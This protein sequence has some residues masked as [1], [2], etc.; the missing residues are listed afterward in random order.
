MP[1][2]R[3]A[4]C[5]VLLFLLLLQLPM[6]ANAELTKEGQVQVLNR[7]N[8]VIEELEAADRANQPKPKPKPKKIDTSMAQSVLEHVRQVALKLARPMRV[9]I[10][11]R[12]T[13]SD[14]KHSF[15]D[16]I[17]MAH[18]RD[19][20][21]I[22]FTEHDRTAVRYGID[23]V[24]GFL[25]YTYERP[26]LHT[27]G[28][29]TFVQ[30]VDAARKKNPN[31][32]IL[33]GTES[34]PG[35]HWEG[36]PLK[37]NFVLHGSDKHIIALG[38]E[39]DSQVKALP[40]YRLK[41]MHSN[42]KLS[43]IFWV[44]VVFLL[45]LFLLFRG[46][47]GIALLV[48]ASFVAFMAT[49]LMQIRHEQNADVDFLDT[50]SQQE[51]FTIWAHPGTKTGM[52]TEA[53]GV[54]VSTPPYSDKIFD[55]PYADAFAAIYGDTDS[56]CEPGGSWDRYLQQYVRRVKDRPIWG[57]AAGDFHYQGGF[58]TYL[59][60]FPM[61]VWVHD[62]SSSGV[63][64][65]LR[66][67]HN[68]NWQQPKDRNVRIRTFALVDNK[69]TTALPGEAVEGKGIFY[70][71]MAADQ[72]L[73]SQGGKLSFS[74]QVVVDSMVQKLVTLEVGAGKLSLTPLHLET[75]K[76]VVRVRIPPQQGFRF[77]ANP[78]FVNKHD[79]GQQGS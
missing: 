60:D 23:P 34:T 65:A 67:G 22:A 49:W 70:L 75:G 68:V 12:S 78:F 69:G 6:D 36:M 45:I 17:K 57:V 26:S 11:V 40:S 5:G 30:D 3:V 4:R 14:G 79:A 55:G 19:I 2:A 63:L 77:E 35:Y 33:A 50:A 52:R 10:D 64:A 18:A 37:G 39:K 13:H 27:T 43:V 31:M 29:E 62:R 42:F 25:G 74:V 59:G 15:S 56:N 9:V 76:H 53:L 72:P 21:A 7:L 38:V 28:V 61:D 8:A 41:H 1:L 20:E 51:L 32:V 24:P 16:L 54:K 47:R 58:D 66:L 73:S 48:F 71:A 46:K 44:A